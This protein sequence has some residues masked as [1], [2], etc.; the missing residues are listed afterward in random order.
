MRAAAL[1]TT[2]VVAAVLTIAAVALAANPPVKGKV[3]PGFTISL[4]DAV[5]NPVTTLEPGPVKIDVEDL[6]DEHNFHLTGPGVDVT[7]EV[8]E[9]GAKTFNLSLQDGTYRFICDPHASSMRGQFT[10]GAGGGGGDTGGGGTGGTTTPPPSAPVGSTLIL[11]S[12]PG[13]TISLKTKAGKKVTRLKPGR[14]TIV[15]RDRSGIHNAHI[16][17]AGVN[18]KTPVPGTTTQTWKVVLKKGTL[19]YQCDPHKQTMRGVVKV[20]A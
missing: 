6:S 19:V 2:F 12:G 13:F 3:G 1:L 4:R 9:I 20:A 7:T 10:V 11:T 8:E 15:A 18:K 14:Y 5:G 16:L 17:G